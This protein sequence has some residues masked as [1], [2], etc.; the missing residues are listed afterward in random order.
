MIGGPVMDDT[1]SCETASH[2]SLGTHATVSVLDRK[3]VRQK[4]VLLVAGDGG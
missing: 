2:E 1:W 3:P 4:E